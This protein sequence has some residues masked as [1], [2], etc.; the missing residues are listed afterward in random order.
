MTLSSEDVE[1]L[2]LKNLAN[3]IRKVNA[4]QVLNGREQAVLE[5]ATNGGATTAAS[6]FAKTQGELA[7]RLGIS[8]KTITNH[9]NDAGAP[10]TRDDGRYDVTAW[11]KFLRANRIID[12]GGDDDARPKRWKEELERLKCETITLD[13]E[14][15]RRELVS[16]PE[17][18][19]AA[20]A[21]VQAIR[22]QLNQLPGRAAQSIVGLTDY[23]EIAEVIQSEIDIILLDL[24]QV[25]FLDQ[26]AAPVIGEVSND[27]E[28][29]P[30][31]DESTLTTG[32]PI[33]RPHRERVTKKRGRTK[34]PSIKVAKTKK[35]KK[36]NR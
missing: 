29:L 21:T 19:S 22:H 25:T 24:S 36:T 17:V 14:E 18:L 7:Q 4:G 20:G 2:A 5:Q 28:D 32:T 23:D 8:R 11:S 16:V 30:E 31:E 3:I 13:L 27:T 6:A 35:R 26:P 15:R 10:P 9:Q 33:E 1:K 12:E 34:L